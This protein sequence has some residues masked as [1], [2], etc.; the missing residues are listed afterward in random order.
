MPQ[1]TQGKKKKKKSSFEQVQEMARRTDKE[2]TN[3]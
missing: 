3:Y 2:D 1:N